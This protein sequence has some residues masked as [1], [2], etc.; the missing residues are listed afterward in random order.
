MMPLSIGTIRNS[1]LALAAITIALISSVGTLSAQQAASNDTAER[2]HWKAV[3]EAQVKLDDKT[4]LGWN[5][6]QPDKKDKRGGKK[7]SDLVLV[8][9]GH[10]Y[11]MI[12]M[13]ARLVYEVPLSSLVVR[14][15]DLES[16]DLAQQ[17]LLVPSSEWTE[18]DV[19]PAEL[20]R[21]TLGDYGRVLEVSLPHP[22]DMR[23][24]Y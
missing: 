5:V 10:R 20:I 8:L 3:S 12:D 14:G 23:P 17:N 1:T 24:F 19:G 22:P 18:R 21:F 16:G 6:F 7:N 9:L 13:R 15:A 11:L 4:P 2:V